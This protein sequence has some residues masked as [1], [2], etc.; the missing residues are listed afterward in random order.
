MLRSSR[1]VASFVTAL[2]VGGAATI[3]PATPALA[4]D[5]PIYRTI[6][7]PGEDESQ[8]MV[9]W[10]TKSKADEVLEVTGPEGTQ[11]FRAEERDYGALLY[12]S[13]FATAT[14]LQ[15]DTEY[16]Y[17]VGSEEGRPLTPAPMA[18]SGLSSPLQT[19][20]SAWTSRSM[21]KRSSGARPSLTRLP[22][23]PMPT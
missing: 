22:M 8:V 1:F 7:Q 13:Q 19:R 14:D 3:V 4:A 16:S 6:L 23:C 2:A 17:R 9:T 12:K 18:M 20:K 21:T 5:S 15:P 11:T 10:R